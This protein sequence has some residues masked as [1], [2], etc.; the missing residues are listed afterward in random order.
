[1]SEVNLFPFV[2]HLQYEKTQPIKEKREKN[3]MRKK[4]TSQFKV[5]IT[6]A[7]DQRSKYGKHL[8]EGTLEHKIHKKWILVGRKA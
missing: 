3:K 2:A 7:M 5:T 4:I 8:S 6:H 1:M